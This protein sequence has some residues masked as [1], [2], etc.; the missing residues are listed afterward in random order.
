MIRDDLVSVIIPVYNSEIY[1]EKCITSLLKQTYKNF[2]LILIDDGSTDSSYEICKKYSLDSRIHIYRKENGGVSSARNMGL[3]CAKGKYIFFVDSD[4]WVDEDYIE[5]L[6]IE[7]DED[8][9]QGGCKDFQNFPSLMSYEEIFNNFAKYWFNSI[10]QFVWGNCYK[11]NIIEE[12]NIR[13]DEKIT[14]GEDAY[15]NLEYLKHIKK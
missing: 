10:V 12:Y 13:F 1:L 14:L 7:D 9:V 2:E 15:F 5:L 8:L 3:N 4:D 6:K 11:K